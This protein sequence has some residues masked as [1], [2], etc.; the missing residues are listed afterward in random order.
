MTGQSLAADHARRGRVTTQ[1]ALHA[2]H[3][4]SVA[5]PSHKNPSVVID[6]QPP[7]DHM[8][9]LGAQY[10][11]PALSYKRSTL[12][13]FNSALNNTTHTSKPHSFCGHRVLRSGGPN[14]VNPH[15]QL[16][17]ILLNRTR[18]LVPP[19]LNHRGLLL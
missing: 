19:T 8:S 17:F 7:Q 6:F 12:R 10:N 18:T 5:I 2:S 9:G 4:P 11:C 13:K 3:R 15:V 14:H 1:G 16:V